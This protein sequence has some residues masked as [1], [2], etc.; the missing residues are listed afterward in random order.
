MRTLWRHA[1]MALAL[2]LT[3]GLARADDDVAAFYKSKTLQVVSSFGE[4]G[5]YFSPGCERW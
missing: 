4:G 5:L 2:A 1:V 3:A